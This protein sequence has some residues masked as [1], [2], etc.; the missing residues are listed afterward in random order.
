VNEGRNP[1]ST[2]ASEAGTVNP[3][4]IGESLETGD[5]N[6]PMLPQLT[7]GHAPPRRVGPATE[8]AKVE[9]SYLGRG[10][11]STGEA[12]LAASA[13]ARARETRRIAREEL[14]SATTAA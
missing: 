9:W 8:T 1:C 11:Q 7:P 13:A 14:R 12:W 4:S 10:Y 3:G 5:V 2:P 6:T